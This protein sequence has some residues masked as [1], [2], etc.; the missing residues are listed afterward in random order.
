MLSVET[1]NRK[2]EIANSKLK[3]RYRKLE[4]ENSKL[5]TRNRKLE[6][7]NSKSKLEVEI[8]NSIEFYIEIIIETRSRNF[9]KK[10]KHFRPIKPI[11][12][13]V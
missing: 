7:K 2:L 8:E 10:I 12:S 13:R 11:F 5:R 6:I 1:Q 3:T 9:E 4:I